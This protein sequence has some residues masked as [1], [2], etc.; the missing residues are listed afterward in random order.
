MQPVFLA[1]PLFSFWE[2]IAIEGETYVEN[3]LSVPENWWEQSCRTVKKTYRDR[4][5]N[6]KI[7]LDG[8]HPKQN[9]GLQVNFEHSRRISLFSSHL[10]R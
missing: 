5:V 10:A 3:M 6:L 2:A 7:E 4:L 8:I 1:E 9:K